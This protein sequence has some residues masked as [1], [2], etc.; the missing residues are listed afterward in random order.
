[1]TQEE[2]PEPEAPPSTKLRRLRSQRSAL[3]YGVV[4]TILSGVGLVALTG[5][6]ASPWLFLGYPLLIAALLISLG[7]VALHLVHRL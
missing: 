4:G 7:A 2:T 6:A 3:T 1:M 5:F